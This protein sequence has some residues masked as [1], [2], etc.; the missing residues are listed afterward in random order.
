MDNAVQLSVEDVHLAFGGTQ[1][2]MNVSFDVSEGELLAIIG[3]NGAGKTSMLNCINSFYRPD[4]GRILFKGHDLTRLSS[5][6]VAPLGIARTFQNIALYTGMSVLENLMAARHV[7]MNHG[8]IEGA[9]YFGRAQRE[10]VKHRIVVE[11]IIFHG[12]DAT[13]RGV[14]GSEEERIAAVET[15]EGVNGVRVVHDELTVG[16]PHPTDDDPVAAPGRTGTA[17]HVEGIPSP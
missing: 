6:R 8:M 9:L 10:E 1:A 15:V 3:P 7:H 4:K 11:E 13:L 17:R 14:I 5:H 2:L 16:A 12:R